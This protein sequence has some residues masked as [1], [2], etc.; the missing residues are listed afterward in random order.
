MP[1]GAPPTPATGRHGRPVPARCAGPSRPG[2]PRSPGRPPR[3]SLCGPEGGRAPAAAPQ[4]MP[5]PRPP[6]AGSN[7]GLVDRSSERVEDEVPRADVAHLAA[8]EPR[9][10][11]GDAPRR[12]A[13]QVVA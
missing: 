10:E 9:L 11:V 7:G 2:L 8:S 3:R 12:E 13:P 5:A 6:D 4:T 1:G